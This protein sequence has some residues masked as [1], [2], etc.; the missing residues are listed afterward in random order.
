VQILDGTPPANSPPVRVVR[1]PGSAYG[2]PGGGYEIVQALVEAA[3]RQGFAA[4][5]Q[6]LALGPV[7]MADSFFGQ[8]GP[9][10]REQMAT[11]HFASRAE[12][13]D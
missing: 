9:S 4:A 7:G 10:R 6:R 2:Y 11:G 1:V 3:S 13:P 8:P 5:A 12:L